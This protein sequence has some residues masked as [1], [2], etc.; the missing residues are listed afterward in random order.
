MIRKKCLF[1]EVPKFFGCRKVKVQFD[2]RPRDDAKHYPGATLK[3]FFKHCYRAMKKATMA[4][5]VTPGCFSELP[6]MIFRIAL[7]FLFIVLGLCSTGEAQLFRRFSRQS[8][9]PQRQGS[10]SSNSYR[11]TRPVPSVKHVPSQRDIE[12][13]QDGRL[14]QPPKLSSPTS[15]ATD[16]SANSVLENRLPESTSTPTAMQYDAVRPAY[17]QVPVRDGSESHVAQSSIDGSGAGRIQSGI[18]DKSSIQGATFE[19]NRMPATV[20]LQMPQ[21][22]VFQK[23]DSVK[24]VTSES[25]LESS[26]PILEVQPPLTET[27]QQSDVQSKSKTAKPVELP[28]LRLPP[29]K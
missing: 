10:F 8:R 26:L 14:Q 16:R 9:V 1:I 6:Q 4:R 11:Y 24:A 15:P 17:I 20:L 27:V 3:L 28:P 25:V 19:S 23:A 2:Y 22:S 7:T 12:E 18:F 21:Y 5:M 13:K 29:A